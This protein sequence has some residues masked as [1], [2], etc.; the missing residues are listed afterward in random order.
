MDKSLLKKYIAIVVSL[1]SCFV[2]IIASASMAYHV[3][4]AGQATASA[5]NELNSTASGDS[6]THESDETG[7]QRPP[8][9]PDFNMLILGIDDAANLPDVILVLAYDGENNAIDIISVPRDTQVVMSP[10]EMD[11]LRDAGRW[12]PNHGI[13]KLNELHAHAGL[14]LGH[15]VLS[16]HIG[17]ILGIDFDHYVIIDLDAFRYIVDAVG[18]IYVDIRPEGMRYNV[19]NAVGGTIEVNLPGGRQL[20][21]GEM[22]EQFVRFRQ[23]RDGD[24]GRIEANQQFMR[25]FFVQVLGREHIM[26]NAGALVRS[27]MTH[28]RTDFGL[29]DALRYVRVAE[30]FDTESIEFHTVPGVPGRAPN[31]A[32]VDLS[33]FFVDAAAARELMDEIKLGNVRQ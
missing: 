7:E 32:G 3:I 24:I 12:F 30:A 2:I 21:D 5:P 17:N 13:V 22:A 8:A 11:M 18:G 14:N 1:I 16:H 23:Y 4:V 28:V 33:W 9:L 26:S 19:D 15:H 29:L 27:F 6:D 10:Y 31:P 25:E 20:L